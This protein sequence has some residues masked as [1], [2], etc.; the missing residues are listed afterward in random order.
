MKL[1]A[2]VAVLCLLMGCKKDDPDPDKNKNIF[3]DSIT[4]K[5]DGVQNTSTSILYVNSGGVIIWATDSI[6]GNLVALQMS[7]WN[8]DSTSYDLNF[9][10]DTYNSIVTWGNS[11]SV[12]ASYG[13]DSV[14]A[15]IENIVVNEAN[16]TFSGTFDAVVCFPSDSV[17][18]LI[19]DGILTNVKY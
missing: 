13:C 2:Y 14:N 7:F 12:Y 19:T 10:Y 5:Y 18:H 1:A 15:H 9:P 6:E 17:S 11:S 8:K 3:T 16:Q 4:W